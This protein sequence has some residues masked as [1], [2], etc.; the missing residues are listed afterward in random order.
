MCTRSLFI[1]GETYGDPIFRIEAVECPLVHECDRNRLTCK[2][3]EQWEND[4]WWMQV[5]RDQKRVPGSMGK[6]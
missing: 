4:D 6:N 1:E 2:I 3:A 5:Y